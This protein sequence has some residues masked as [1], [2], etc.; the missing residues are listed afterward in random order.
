MLSGV[1]RRIAASLK[2]L[3]DMAR[4]DAIIRLARAGALDLRTPLAIASGIP[5]LI[6]R[7]PSTGILSRM[8][9][10]SVGKKP[11]VIDRDGVFTWKQIDERSDRVTHLLTALGMRPGD[12]IAMLLRNG[13]EMA[14]ILIAAQKLGVPACPINTWAKAAEL[15]S[16]LESSKPKVLFFDAATVSSPQVDNATTLVAVGGSADLSHV[17]YEYL[18]DEQSKKPIAPFTRDPGSPTVVI[19][20]SGTTGR[21]KGASRNAANAGIKALTDLLQVVPLRRDDRVFCPAPMFH[22]FGLAIFTFATALGATLILPEAFKPERALQSIEEDEAT[23]AAFVPVMLRRIVGLEES[24][25]SRYDLNRL[26][27][28]ISS[29]SALSSQLRSEL[30]DVFGD[31]IYDLYGSTEVGWVTIATPQDMRERPDAAGKP[32]RGVDVAILS[33]DGK[34]LPLGEVGRIFVRSGVAFE[35]YTTGEKIDSNG[36]YNSIGD[37]GFLDSDG[38]LYIEGRSDDMV[39]IGGENVY[40]VEV[41]QVIEALPGVVEAAVIGIE[42]DEFGQVLAAFVEGTITPEDVEAA[43]RSKLASYKVPRKIDVMAELPRN[44]T[45]KVAKKELLQRA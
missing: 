29:G 20:T 2:P 17:S 44:A 24:A 13:H 8:N 34:R 9:A 12:S 18:L 32:V 31:V 35:G 3:S 16:V 43:C 7:G 27:V 39:V 30:S 4:P 40:P 36:G 22:S 38:Y 5:W 25:L 33:E 42:D 1:G 45:G 37:V 10:T 15:R 21:P 11:A 19:H 23:A 28:V 41:E 14:E 6:G 26:R